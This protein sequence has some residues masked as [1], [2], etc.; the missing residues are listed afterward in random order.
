MDFCELFSKKFNFA[1]FF[2]K[3]VSLDDRLELLIR[4][5]RAIRLQAAEVGTLRALLR[6][7]EIARGPEVLAVLTLRAET[8][9]TRTT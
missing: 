3:S 2:L 4:V 7:P 5:D 9:A 8:E 1:N 6:L